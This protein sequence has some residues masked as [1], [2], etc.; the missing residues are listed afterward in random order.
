MR[1]ATVDTELT[2]KRANSTW[3]KKAKE[4]RWEIR[5]K[6]WDADQRQQLQIA[7]EERRIAGRA[8]RIDA[9]EGSLGLVLTAIKAAE[10]DKMDVLTARMHL[11][12]L[13]PML[14]D[15][16]KAHRLELGEP[17]EI[18]DTTLTP[19]IQFSADDLAAAQRQ[20]DE[21]F[22]APAHAHAE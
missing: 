13:R 16:L 17:T 3:R 12:T 5:A 4:Y 10:L 7:T 21:Y 9:I 20:L 18:S 6:A 2:A 1:K 15:M 14:A 11:Q 22:K 8:Y 19:G